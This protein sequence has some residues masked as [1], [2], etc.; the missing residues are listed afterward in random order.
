MQGAKGNFQKRFSGK[1]A[2]I[3]PYTCISIW[4]NIVT[5]PIWLQVHIFNVAVLPC[6][7]TLPV[8][9]DRNQKLSYVIKNS[10]IVIHWLLLI[11]SSWSALGT[12]E[13]HKDPATPQHSSVAPLWRLSQIP[14]SSYWEE[15]HMDPQTPFLCQESLAASPSCETKIAHPLTLL[16]FFC[17]L[18]NVLF[19]CVVCSCWTFCPLYSPV[20]ICI[21]VL[22]HGPRGMFVS[23]CTV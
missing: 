10:S 3:W 21:L 17:L 9:N 22:H 11:T 18:L 12:F 19:Y 20:Y 6:W 1:N 14:W 4:L 13:T 8:L 15:P 7:G 5:G 2:W 23:L 16:Y